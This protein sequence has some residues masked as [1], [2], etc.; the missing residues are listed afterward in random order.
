VKWQ[1]WWLRFAERLFCDF[2]ANEIK[3]RKMTIAQLL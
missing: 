3:A 1:V 2:A